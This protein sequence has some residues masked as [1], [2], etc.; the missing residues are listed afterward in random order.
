VHY[1]SEGAVYSDHW[2]T[3]EVDPLFDGVRDDPKFQR[4]RAAARANQAVQA[5]RVM[6]LR[7]EGVIPDRRS[8][9]SE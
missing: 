9:Q 7:Q 4:L 5:A 1:S 3:F 6:Q 2:L 8:T